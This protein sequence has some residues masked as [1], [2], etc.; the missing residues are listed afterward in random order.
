M[1]KAL[2]GD[3]ALG[4]DGFTIGFSQACE[5][6][7]ADIM[8]AFHY[9]HARATFEKKLPWNLHFSYT[10]ELGVVDTKEFRPISLVRGV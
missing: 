3:K 9:F 8:N 6:L 4:P 2:N 1:V 10:K 5:V 7:K